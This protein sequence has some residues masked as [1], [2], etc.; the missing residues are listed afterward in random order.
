MRRATSIFNVPEST[1]CD[2]I[3]GKRARSNVYINNTCLTELE[4]KTFIRYI[5]NL[6]SRGFA[7][8]LYNVEDI[9]NIIA[10]SRDALRVG[11]R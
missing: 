7:P 8:R 1:I 2:K 10:E 3:K 11:T 6:D 5:I 9:A 4:K